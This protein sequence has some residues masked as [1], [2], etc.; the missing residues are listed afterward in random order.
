M[1]NASKDA[2]LRSN[3][4]S[5][6]RIELARK[7]ASFM[8][9]EENRA[10]EIHGLTLHRRIAPTAP[11]SMTYEP[12]VTVMAQGRKRVDLGRT[13]FI[14]GE[15]RYLLTSL[16]LPIVSQVIEASEKVPSLAMSLK[17]EMPMIREL[18]SR[19]EIQ[20]GR[21]APRQ[22]CN[23]DRGS[24]GGISQRVLPAHRSAGCSSRH[25]FSEW[26]DSTRNHLSNTS[27][28]RGGTPSSDCHPRRSEPQDGKS[29]CV[30]QSKL[31][32]AST[33]GRSGANRGNGSIHTAPSF[34][35]A[36]R[37]ES[38]SIPEAA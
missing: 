24:H 18:L 3:R 13:S 19:E 12:S 5:E 34:S 14:Y 1:K 31:R 35:C 36:D 21:G 37:H 33:Y 9:S 17:L 16:D 22:S 30:D 23:G 38:S 2:T 29:H 7:I 11:C 32:E 20:G 28:T 25:S 6:L 27:R 26:T 4:A 15:S 8:G 10:T